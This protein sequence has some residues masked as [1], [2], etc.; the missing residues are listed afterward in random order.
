VFRVDSTG[1]PQKARVLIVDSVMTTGATI[2]AIARSVKQVLPQAEVIC[3]VLGKADGRLVNT[4]LNPDYFL[5]ASPD[6]GVRIQAPARSTVKDEQDTDRKV[7]GPATD[8]PAVVPSDPNEPDSNELTIEEESM[9]T[10]TK[11]SVRQ[12][13]KQRMIRPAAPKA[14]QRS[15]RKNGSKSVRMYVIGLVVIFL[16]LGALGPL[17]SAR[18][19]VTNTQN[20]PDALPV[21]AELDAGAEADDSA[22]PAEPVKA[23]VDNYPKGRVTVPG[24]GL[25][26]NHSLESRAVAR[27]KMRNGERV[28]ILGRYAPNVGPRWLRIKTRSGKVGWVFAS[29][30]KE[31]RFR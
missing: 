27:S 31:S 8:H 13:Q 20:L 5:G 19:S 4:H 23:V 14:A 10:T 6:A 12:P 9:S 28:S 17:R 29:V 24:V 25:R 15:T 2:E 30:V 22:A 26:V 16:I 3:F 18:N 11:V 7:A 1:L 21:A